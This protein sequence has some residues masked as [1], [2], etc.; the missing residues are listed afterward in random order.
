MTLSRRAFLA[1]FL[2]SASGLTPTPT[3][4]HGIP[5]PGKRFILA[6][7]ILRGDGSPPLENHAVLVDAGQ[8]AAILPV[9]SLKDQPT[10]AYPGATIL[11]G[12]IN[13]HV[14]RIHS[15]K[16]R[17]ERYLEHGVTSIGDAASRLTALPNLLDSPPGKTA[18]AACAGPML[19]PPGGYPL[20]VHS[21]DHGLVVRSP[22]HGRERVRQLAD[23]G[24]TLA[25]LAFEPGPY[26]K[27]W[28]LFN[29]PTA[30]AI[31]DEARKHGMTIRCHLEDLG[32]LEPALNA[33]VHVVDHVPHRRIAD[34]RPRDVLGKENGTLVPTPHYIRLLERMVREKIILVPTLDVFSRSMWHGPELYEP[35]RAFNNMGGRIAVG[36]DF[37]YR[38]TD[39]GMPLHEMR[40][41][42]KAGLD[43]NAILSAATQGSAMACGMDSRG[44]IAPGKAA[45]LLIV[46]GNPLTSIETLA[47]PIHIIKDGIFIR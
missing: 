44:V 46:H 31:C 47:K 21:A 7:T 34:G 1:S 9:G 25:K 13:C 3:A 15:R 20:P 35:V 6:G 40:L 37:P 14:H 23:A 17:R 33:G 10:L 5:M 30:S 43:G 32:G 2:A 36:N 28:P 27:P 19:C 29:L 11:P 41:L 22:Q 39:A 8:I 26:S 12:I 38:R 18:T 24:T 42:Q 4:S 45:D 16:E